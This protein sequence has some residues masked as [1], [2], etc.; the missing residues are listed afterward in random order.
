M[1]QVVCDDHYRA[2]ECNCRLQRCKLRYSHLLTISRS[3]N[4]STNA[5][6]NR[7]ALSLLQAVALLQR[8]PATS[9]VGSSAV[10][11]PTVTAAVT[12][13]ETV[14]NPWVSLLSLLAAEGLVE[15]VLC[16]LDA[17]EAAGVHRGEQAWSSV[18]IAAYRSSSSYSSSNSRSSSSDSSSN[19]RSSSSTGSSSERSNS[20]SRSATSAA[21]DS[22]VVWLDR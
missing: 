14:I 2:A 18:V 4:L 15:E 9:A 12:V 10:T 8:L 3:R 13:S 6:C 20:S 17:M 7:I 1:Q 16:V 19:S 5:G 21:A 11:P 22:A